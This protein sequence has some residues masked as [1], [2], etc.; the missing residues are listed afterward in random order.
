MSGDFPKNFDKKRE[1]AKRLAI[2]RDHGIVGVLI[3]ILT[4]NPIG[5]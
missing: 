5:L 4:E 1:I 2:Q 3:A